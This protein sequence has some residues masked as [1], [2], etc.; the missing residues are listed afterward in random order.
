[1]SGQR[2]QRKLTSV[3]ELRTLIGEPG[4]LVI[5]KQLTAL[6][7]HMRSFIEQ[8]P[9]ALL[10]TFDRAG[11]CD[12][13]PRGD[14]PGVAKVL[15]DRTLV[16]A[17]RPSN[18]LADS[19]QN[20]LETGRIGLLFMIPGR[21]ETL[22]VNGRACVFQDEELLASL[23]VREK[24]PL[25]GIAVEVTQCYLHCAKAILRSKL[26]RDAAERPAVNIPSLAAMLADQVAM[27]GI[28]VASLT[29]V[30]DDSYANRLY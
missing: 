23:A 12:V 28:T 17:E 26:W 9:L 8:A 14:L 5:K 22:R 7:R 20:I 6:D 2:F 29:D 11:N 30:I 19:L 4:E 18:R 24:T 10:G 16:I 21:G 27:E 25:L 15:D 13:S 1:M 3:A